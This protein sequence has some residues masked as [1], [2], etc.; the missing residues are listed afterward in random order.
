MQEPEQIYSKSI[1]IVVHL[2][3]DWLRLNL[4]DNK[5]LEHKAGEHDRQRETIEK[6]T[7]GN[8]DYK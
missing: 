8:E 1:H 4:R 7:L 3:T 6:T 2:S 5:G